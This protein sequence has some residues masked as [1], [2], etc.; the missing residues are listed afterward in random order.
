[1][2]TPGIKVGWLVGSRSVSA[3]TTIRS[4]GVLPKQSIR[5]SRKAFRRRGGTEDRRAEDRASSSGRRH[6]IVEKY[7]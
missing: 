3:S 7:F 2:P 5:S 1:M 4:L 6:L